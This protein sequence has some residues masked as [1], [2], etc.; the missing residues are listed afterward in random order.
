MAI[1]TKTVC[2]Y[3]G[4][5]V[6]MIGGIVPIIS[7]GP[8][9]PPFD[10]DAFIRT[11]TKNN[12]SVKVN[13]RISQVSSQ[14]FI[15]RL[16]ADLYGRRSLVSNERRDIHFVLKVARADHRWAPG[17][18]YNRVEVPAEFV[19]PY[20]VQYEDKVLLRPGKYTFVFV[21]YDPILKRGNIWRKTVQTPPFRKE[22]NIAENSTITADV[23]FQIS[24]GKA[25][26]EEELYDKANTIQESE[27]LPVGNNRKLCIDIIANTSIDYD[28]NPLLRMKTIVDNRNYARMQQMKGFFPSIQVLQ[29]ASNLA[30][31]QLKNGRVLVTVVD[32]LRMEH[33]YDRIDAAKIDWQQVQETVIKQDSDK[34]AIDRISANHAYGQFLYDIISGIM[35]D[36]CMPEAQS[37][38]RLIIVVNAELRFPKKTVIPKLGP[39]N[40]DNIRVIQ[41]HKEGEFAYDDMYKILKKTKPIRYKDIWMPAILTSWNQKKPSKEYLVMKD[42]VLFLENLK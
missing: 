32:A 13:L 35:H 39:V 25:K 20:M 34:I 24:P 37:P 16:N 14:R 11:H 18:S 42:F 33:L 29:T 6:I 17:L 12:L 28:F 27:W 8:D 21:V 15:A 3:I 31:L 26:E 30:H 1:H 7:A 40:P 23:E 36:S 38:F 10:V 4:F 41:I 9:F 5:L 22:H 2:R 19:S